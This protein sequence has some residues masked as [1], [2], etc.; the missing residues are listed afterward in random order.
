MRGKVGEDLVGGLA[1]DEHSPVLVSVFDP[2]VDVAADL[3]DAVMSDSAEVL[4]RQSESRRS[5][6]FSHEL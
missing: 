4:H 6:W 1:P 3:D 2:V 5:S